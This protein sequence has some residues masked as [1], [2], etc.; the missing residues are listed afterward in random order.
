MRVGGKK[1]WISP[2]EGLSR[3]HNIV[4]DWDTFIETLKR[5]LPVC[6]WTNTLRTSSESVATWLQKEGITAVPLTW[7][8][9]AFRLE[10]GVPPGNRMPYL[11]GLYHVQE[12]VS[13]LPVHLL[14][15]APGHRVI[16]LCAAPGNK[17]AQL[18][19]AMNNEGTLIANDAS[20]ERLHVVFSTLSRLGLIN[21]STSVCDAADYPLNTRFDRVLAD[22]PCSCEGT[23]RKQKNVFRKDGGENARRMAA[24][25]ERIL[26]R[27]LAI[28]KPG[29]RVVY[30]TCTYAPEENE[31]VIDRVLKK[32]DTSARLVPV[33]V[34][35]LVYSEGLIA[36]DGETYNPDLRN[37]LRIWPHQNDSGGFFSAVIEKAGGYS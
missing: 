8:P 20:E 32:S 18:A 2:E 12:E 30:S 33:R 34:N 5:P 21:V 15:T 31:R 29:G 26:E 25:Q 37:C 16:D 35:G 36:W 10:P 1:S 23:S 11:A 22:V 7:Y 3:Y 19:V 14:E 24:R 13:L 6:V 17:T 27:A 28:C 4:D 9:D